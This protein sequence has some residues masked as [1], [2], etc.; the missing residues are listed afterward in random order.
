M[1]MVSMREVI[2]FKKICFRIKE[3]IDTILFIFFIIYFIFK[4]INYVNQLKCQFITQ[5]ILIFN[6][7]LA[8]YLFSFKYSYL[9]LQASLKS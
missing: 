4:T 1:R 8:S 5:L 7:I 6:R 9:T 2:R 3:A